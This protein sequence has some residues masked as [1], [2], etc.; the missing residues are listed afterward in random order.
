MANLLQAAI[1][2]EGTRPLMWNH[3]GPEAIPLTR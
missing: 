1:T 3:F 2:I